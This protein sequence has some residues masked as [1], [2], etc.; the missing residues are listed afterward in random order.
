MTKQ[1]STLALALEGPLLH[2]SRSLQV[3]YVCYDCFSKS[4]LPYKC[5]V[6]RSC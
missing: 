3:L 6:Y 4:S 5:W 1:Y 2:K